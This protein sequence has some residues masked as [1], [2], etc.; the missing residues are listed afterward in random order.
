MDRLNISQNKI[1]RETATGPKK[2]KKALNRK[3]RQ[4]S[5][6]SQRANEPATT[7]VQKLKVDPDQARK[8]GVI[9]KMWT[10]EEDQLLQRAIAKHGERN[11]RAIADLVPG[12]SYIQCLQRWKKALRPGLRKGHW[13]KEEDATLLRLVD[14]YKPDWDWS[15]ISKQIPGRN[16]KQCRERW[17]LN[18]DPSINRGPWTPEE[19]EQLLNFVAQC[20]C[21]VIRDCLARVTCLLCLFA[22][23][24]RRTLGIDLKTYG[25]EDGELSEDA[26]S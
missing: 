21:G 13:S 25:R 24:S 15:L 3:K 2:K 16:A 18:L 12:R 7:K 9:P 11:W 14:Q 6:R 10:P 8:P 19:D 17:F 22:L 20:K 23:C 5:E 26:V 1:V 4:M